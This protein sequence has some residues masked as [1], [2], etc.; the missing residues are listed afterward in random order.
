MVRNAVG[1]RLEPKVGLQTYFEPLSRL[2]DSTGLSGK[3][4]AKASP[5]TDTIFTSPA[6]DTSLNRYLA[7]LSS[8]RK[9]VLN[10]LL[11]SLYEHL[12]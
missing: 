7:I 8:Q 4:T 11:F 3:A 5:T 2:K 12:F 10:N 9:Q 1:A 6:T